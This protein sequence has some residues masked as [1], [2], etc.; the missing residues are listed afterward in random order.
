MDDLP[1]NVLNPK[2]YLEAKKIADDTY[3]RHSIY[4]SMFIVNTYQKLGGRYEGKKTDGTGKWLKQKW[5]SVEDYL[6]GD[7]IACGDAST[8]NNLCRPLYKQGDRDLITIKDVI[9]KHG[10]KAIRNIIKRKQK[11]MDRYID[12]DTLKLK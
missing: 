7:I 10:E 3:K 1:V 11:N 5:V 6:N 8:V 9:K 2:L 12:W 4:K